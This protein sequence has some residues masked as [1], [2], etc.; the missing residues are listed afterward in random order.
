MRR[1]HPF[2]CISL[3]ANFRSLESEKSHVVSCINI[4]QNAGKIGGQ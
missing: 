3:E 4:D 1:H 2:T